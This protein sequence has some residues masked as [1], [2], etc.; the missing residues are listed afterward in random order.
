[1][2]I[3]NK[4]TVSLKINRKAGVSYGDFFYTYSSSLH[5]YHCCRQAD[6]KTADQR[7]T[8]FRTSGHSVDFRYRGN[9]Y[10]KY[11]AALGQW[12][13]SYRRTSSL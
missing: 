3:Q 12:I 5:S 13:P 11:R 1:M 10:A 4:G 9:P 6:G 7:V 2:G 8:D